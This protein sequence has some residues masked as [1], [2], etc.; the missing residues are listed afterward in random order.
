MLT[1]GAV[2]A[3]FAGAFAFE[4]LQARRWRKVGRFRL[5]TALAAL[6]LPL[7][8]A[9]FWLAASRPAPPVFPLTSF[10][11]GWECSFAGNGGSVCFRDVPPALHEQR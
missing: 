11:P 6:M 10:G 5:W 7:S 3:V 4:A 1:L 2:L 8:G 9:A